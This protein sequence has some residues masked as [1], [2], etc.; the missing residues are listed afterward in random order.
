MLDALSLI[1]KHRG[2]GVLVDT[3]L[4]VLLFVGTVNRN[5]IE[6]FKR[7]DA[8]TVADYDL[9]MRLLGL[10]DRVLATPHVLAQVSDLTD[11]HGPE[12]DRVRAVFRRF[13][14][15]VEEHW[16]ASRE[17]VTDPIF[18]RL[19][20]TDAAIARVCSQGVL[21]LTADSGLQL[22][23]QDRGLDAVNFNHIRGLGW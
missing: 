14:E 11:L 16:D 19:G 5:R 9:L 12:L 13:V 10:F 7:T 20:L 23:L 22:A 1:Q 21:V 17:I 18:T 15:E 4:L 6:R 2:R 3:N 8:F